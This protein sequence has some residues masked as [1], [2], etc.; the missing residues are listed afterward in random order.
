VG[1]LVLA[2]VFFVALAGA[3]PGPSKPAC[4]CQ[5]CWYV[6]EPPEGAPMCRKVLV[7]AT[8]GVAALALWLFK[9]KKESPQCP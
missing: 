5:R 3:R 2:L 8:V 7:I 9:R 4:D 6:N 1:W